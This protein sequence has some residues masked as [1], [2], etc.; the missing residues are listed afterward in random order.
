MVAAAWYN[1]LDVRSM[2]GRSKLHEV[3]E[4]SYKQPHHHF[5][6]VPIVIRLGEVLQ[7]SP[8]ANISLVEDVNGRN[9]DGSYK[10]R[11]PPSLEV[12]H[13]F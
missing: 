3:S 7:L 12:Q 11:D 13:A 6:R 10:Y 4:V 2:H 8:T 5:G 9:Q 1:M